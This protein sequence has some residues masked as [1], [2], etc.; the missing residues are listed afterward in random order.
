MIDKNSIFKVFIKEIVLEKEN[1]TL[2]QMYFANSLSLGFQIEQI[3][4]LDKIILTTIFRS[5]IAKRFAQSVPDSY[6]DCERFKK[7]RL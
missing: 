5:I 6:R 1:R 4:S 7:Y 3:I 2:S